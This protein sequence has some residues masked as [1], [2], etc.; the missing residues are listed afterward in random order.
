MLFEA[1]RKLMIVFVKGSMS[2]SYESG[3]FIISLNIFIISPLISVFDLKN[4]KAEC[5]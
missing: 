4:T 3:D 5:K 1:D 2:R